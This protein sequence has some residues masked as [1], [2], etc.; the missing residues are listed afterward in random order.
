MV[1]IMQRVCC[2]P[3]VVALSPVQP[4]LQATN[5]VGQLIA[6]RNVA[7]SEWHIDCDKSKY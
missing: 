7:P 2:R 4:L 3:Q 5:E 6:C 1:L